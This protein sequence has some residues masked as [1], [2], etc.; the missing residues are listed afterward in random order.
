MDKNNKW[1]SFILFRI[2]QNLWLAILSGEFG[3]LE[4]GHI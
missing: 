2:F 4:P 3:E 1:T